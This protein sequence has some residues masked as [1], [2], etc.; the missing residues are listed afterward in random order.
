MNTDDIKEIK[1]L[2]ILNFA[3][4]RHLKKLL[5]S[6][7]V[8]PKDDIYDYA[9]SIADYMTELDNKNRNLVKDYPHL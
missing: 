3:E 9:N 6:H 5:I 4:I 2:C 7:G 1:R 8:I